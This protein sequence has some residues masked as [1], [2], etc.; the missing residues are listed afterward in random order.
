MEDE[1]DGVIVCIE[2]YPTLL[3]ENERASLETNINLLKTR[4]FYE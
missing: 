1:G 2:K 3:N 4:L